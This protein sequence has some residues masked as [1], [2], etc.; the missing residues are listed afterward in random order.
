M[1]AADTLSAFMPAQP[2]GPG[3]PVVGC[4]VCG[5]P[6]HSTAMHPLLEVMNRQT[7]LLSVLSGILEPK[8]YRL[9]GETTEDGTGKGTIVFESWPGGV[10]RIYL[11]ER[12][13]VYTNST[14][15]PV[16]GMYVTEGLPGPVTV[17][18]SNQP[19]VPALNARDLHDYSNLLIAA[20]DNAIA[21]ALVKGAEKL[22]FQWTGLSAGA[23]CVARVQMRLTWQ[24]PD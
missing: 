22:V 14:G 10:D 11:V 23:R 24:S 2:E 1:S 15:T 19:I 20:N 5:N 17:G 4:G 8:R 16:V 7:E 21:P 9:A 12:S 18:A 3:G 13:I 6:G